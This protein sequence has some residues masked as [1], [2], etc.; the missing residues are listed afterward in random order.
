VRSS[1]IVED[2]AEFS[3]AGQFETALD[4]RGDDAL[5][6]AI[7]RCLASRTHQRVRAYQ[8]Q[9]GARSIP[10]M[11]VVVQRF[12][13]SDV[14][15][16]LFTRD[17]TD[18]SAML[19]EMGRG[20]N[21]VAGIEPTA[22]VRFDRETRSARETMNRSF[23]I[24]QLVELGIRIET[25][26]ESPCDIEW[27]FDGQ[28][29][30]ILQARP[31]TT[32]DTAERATIIGQ[33][34]EHA[35]K[36]AEPSG[37]VWVRQNL[38]DVLLHPTPMTWALMQRMLSGDGGLGRMY[39][40]FGCNPDPGLATIGVYDLIAGR[41]YLN[42]SREP[43]MQYGNLPLGHSFARLK[44][45]PSTAI[46]AQA[47]LL[48]E[49]VGVGTLL[50]WPIMAWR[51]RRMLR[52]IG[53]YVK[54]FSQRFREQ[55]VP[56]FLTACVAESRLDYA[57]QSTSD[58]LGRFEQWCEFVL[59]EF[60]R[61]SLKA[62]ALADHVMRDVK[63]T[64]DLGALALDAEI[65]FAGGLRS[66]AVG[67][68]QESKFLESFGHRGLHEMEL[69]QPRFDEVP[70]RL[71]QPTAANCAPPRNVLIAPPDRLREFI[72][73]RETAKHWLMLGTA[74]L[75]RQLI[76]LDRRFDLHG[77]VF[78]LTPDEL[79]R[80]AAGENLTATIT[81]RRRRWA[82]LKSLPMPTV[83]FSDDLAAIGRTPEPIGNS[84]QIQGVALSAGVAEGTALVLDEPTSVQESAY[85]LVCPTSDPAW[86]PLMLQAS[87]V[88]FESSGMLSHGAIVAREFG[89]PAV[90]GIADATLRVQNGQRLRV[91]GGA[92]VV[93]LLGART[94]LL[95]PLDDK[96]SRP[97][98]LD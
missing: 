36:L 81:A 1:A 34:L 86:T 22:R 75:R 88:V 92:G 33:E 90:G 71:G 49:R 26:C 50:L 16:V 79:P 47:E 59:G 70:P 57:G 13:Q 95:S 60:A 66:F 94:K 58:L 87:A 3:F 24:N 73:L 20:T 4:V 21:V 9:I 7:D 83:F 40:D 39:R 53:T 91:D 28:Q 65:D 45:D 41:P 29:Y 48:Q 2:S 25:F 77:G 52:R 84:P 5:I 44:A 10:T 67:K 69:S 97:R 68:M 51:L 62:A 93:T 35:R 19:V 37:T 27:T 6:A 23:P 56:P 72:E 30:W 64:T 61:H 46:G 15:G 43:R 78:F 11:A 76:E 54:T 74:Q 31:I 8:Q 89:L 98:Q 12:V 18:E 85:V 17:P 32:A 82:V 14:A 80:L 96:R 38:A 42:L 55:I 63:Q